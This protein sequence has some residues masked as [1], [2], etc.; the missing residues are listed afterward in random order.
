MRG[1]YDI[2]GCVLSQL[3]SAL[4][5]IGSTDSWEWLRDVLLMLP[6]FSSRVFSASSPE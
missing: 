5:G 4:C 6:R 3:I 1:T 2:I